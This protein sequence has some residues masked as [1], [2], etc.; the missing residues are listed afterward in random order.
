MP[1]NPTREI[2]LLRNG[3]GASPRTLTR[4]EIARL[5][6][7]IRTGRPSLMERDYAIMQLMLQAGLRVH[8]VATLQMSDLFS[9]RR[10][11]RLQVRGNRC[12]AQRV[13]PLNSVA[14]RALQEYLAVRPAIPRIAHLFV[15]QRGQPLSMRSIQRVIDTYARAAGLQGVCAQS[16]RHTCAK[17]LLE[18]TRDATRVAQWLGHR[19][20]RMLDRYMK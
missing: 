5:S 14:A 4:S 11:I 16:L 10:A 2:E 18:E 15:S 7:A 13:V 17:T 9:M 20:A 12:S 3:N 8:E 19:N 6:D 1:E